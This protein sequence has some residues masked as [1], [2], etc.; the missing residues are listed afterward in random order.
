MS[1][2]ERLQKELEVVYAQKAM[3]EA[4]FIIQV[5]NVNKRIDY[6]NQKILTAKGE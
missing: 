5:D 6:L 4:N 2:K 3:I 1:E